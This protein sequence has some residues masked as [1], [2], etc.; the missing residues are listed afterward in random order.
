MT[1]GLLIIIVLVTAT[2]LAINIAS[3]LA[4]RKARFGPHGRVR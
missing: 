3:W 2:D 1:L 4:V